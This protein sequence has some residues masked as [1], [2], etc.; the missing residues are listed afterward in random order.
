M[1]VLICKGC[2]KS[3]VWG[4]DPHGQRIPLDPRSPVYR[5]LPAPAY[6]TDDDRVGIVLVER[7]PTAMVPHSVTCASAND[8][9]RRKRAYP[10][11][12]G[13]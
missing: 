8:F 10:H 5:L 9:S 13:E 1:T 12:A 3:I 6:A 7:D 4:T 11:T 2:G